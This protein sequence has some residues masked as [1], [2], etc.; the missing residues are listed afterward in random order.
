MCVV[1]KLSLNS[2]I[3]AAYKHRLLSKSKLDAGD[4]LTLYWKDFAA[5]QGKALAPA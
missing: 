3:E 4:E 5:A 1:S 2:M